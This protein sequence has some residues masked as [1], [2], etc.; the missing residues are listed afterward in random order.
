MLSKVNVTNAN[1]KIPTA[2]AGADKTVTGSSITISGSGTDSDGSITGYSWQ[3]ISGPGA[4]LSSITSPTLKVTSLVSGTYVFRLQVKDSRGDT[5]SDYV[6]VT[7]Q[8][9]TGTNAAPVVNAG[10][11]K[12][13]TLPAN[14]I[15]I[16]GS[17]ND[18]DGS[19]SSYRW[20][21]VS[22]G[23]VTLSGTASPTLKAS[24]LVAGSYVFRLTV[25]DNGGAVKSDDMKL[26]VKS[27]TTTTNVAP[28]VSAG[29][30]RLIALPVS[31]VTLFGS[32]SDKDGKIASIKWTKVSGGT[33]AFSSTTALRPTIR[34]FAPGTYVFRITV[35][36]NKGAV[37]SDDVTMKFS[38]PPVVNAGS[39]KS[40]S[41][42]LNSLVL[43][44]TAS[45]KDGQVKRYSWSKYSG[46][47]V[48]LTNK[49]T[50][51]VTLSRFSK[52]TYVLRL[53]VWDDAG[54]QS[55][56]LI[57]VKVL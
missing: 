10:A 29:P 50:Q 51:K 53:A 38:Y 54:L 7:V 28:V 21:K 20:S 36:D 47:A 2:N 56:D 16:I 52:G 42:S 49:D 37:K 6:K 24:G 9:G 3:K 32:A 48:M 35:T 14:S 1:N 46:P 33:C 41:V 18:A 44:G 39:D 11:D 5:D 23:A 57:T 34:Q 12:T 8:S 55:S 4:T 27:S 43:G 45:D 15:S 31:Y 30:N 17:A 19:I 40:I 25:K 22:G 26:V 13:I